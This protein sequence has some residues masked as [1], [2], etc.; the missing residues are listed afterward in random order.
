[1]MSVFQLSFPRRSQRS[2]SIV[3]AIDKV[4]ENL[5]EVGSLG[6][7]ATKGTEFEPG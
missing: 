6:H 1:M 7:R 5:E 4:L 3:D 2:E